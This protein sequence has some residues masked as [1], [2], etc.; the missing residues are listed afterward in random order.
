V[1]RLFSI[2]FWTFFAVSCV[3]CFFIACALWLVTLPF[4]RDRRLNHLFS[5]AWG[6]LYAVAYPGWDVRVSGRQRIQRG[7]AYVIVANHTSIA[8]IVLCFCLFRQFKWVSKSTVFKYPFLGWNMWLS[9]YVPLVR[10]DK[11]SITKMMARSRAWLERGVSML[12]FPEGTRSPDGRVLPFKHGA[13]TLALDAKVPVVPV[14]IHG[15]HALIPK[16]GGTFATR[17]E[18]HVEVLDPVVAPEGA[19]AESF[20]EV[21]RERIIAALESPDAQRRAA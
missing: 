10:G 20:A 5:C 19:T 8:D 13:F 16:H 7:Q 11:D 12:L 14:A 2:A 17:A 6:A 15:G 3:V 4:D 1:P 9:R 18:L 21:V